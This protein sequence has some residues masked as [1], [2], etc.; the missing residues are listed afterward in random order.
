MV[1]DLKIVY[2]LAIYPVSTNMTMK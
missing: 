2:M 1:L